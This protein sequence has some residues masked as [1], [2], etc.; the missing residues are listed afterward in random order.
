VTP[1]DE[2][3]GPAAPQPIADTGGPAPD[4]PVP[5]PAGRSSK[6]DARA[7]AVARAVELL[8]SFGAALEVGDVAVEHL[9]AIDRLRN[10]AEAQAN[11]WVLL[12]AAKCRVAENFA[13]WLERWDAARDRDAGRERARRQ[14]A[15]RRLSLID[16]PDGMGAI[17]GELPPAEFEMLQ[18]TLQTIDGE[19]SRSGDREAGLT[20]KQRMADA[21]DEMAH[22][23]N[24]NRR[25]AVTD[26]GG[27]LRTAIVVLVELDDLLAGTG[28]GETLD[29]RPIDISEIR[30]MAADAHLIPMVL[31][32]DGVPLDMGR[33]QR[34]ADDAQATAVRVRDGG[35]VLCGQT[36]AGSLD[37]HHCHPWNQ[38]GRTDLA[39]LAGTC[40]TDHRA[41]HATGISIRVEHGRAIA[42]RRD[43]TIVPTH[44]RRRDARPEPDTPPDAHPRAG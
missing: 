41:V 23:A 18:R 25:S 12:E 8:A 33:A 30:R 37:A 9:L 11:E 3:T 13:R 28:I 34:Y 15:A 22:R 38:G 35:C 40:T 1:G 24:A 16:Q 19:L 21:L 5:A 44:N 2:H 10:R 7:A 14:R 20:I 31:N 29:G 4:P 6:E 26:D 43:G 27:S 36:Y 42:R 39:E 32:G 17:H